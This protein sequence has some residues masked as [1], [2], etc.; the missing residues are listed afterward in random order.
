MKKR[1][2]LFCFLLFSLLAFNILG[3]TAEV[4][5][6]GLGDLEENIE[7]L[8]EK[9]EEIE[10]LPENIETKWDY[11]G[12]E[13]K[14]V[15]LKN[16]LV[17][18]LDSFFTQISVIFEVL[19]GEPYS[20]SLTLFFIVLLWFYLLFKI[21]EILGDFGMFSPAISWAMSFVVVMLI[22]RTDGIKSVVGFFGNLIF[23]QESL[24]LKWII[25]IIIAVIMIFIY[26]FSSLLGESYKATKE[27][28]E[29]EE[30]KRN[31]GILKAYA[32]AIIKSFTK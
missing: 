20:L 2:I 22:S 10:N 18:G 12:N 26:K 9:A 29:K 32:D 7:D 11:L 16:K 24:G 23:S 21:K 30:E 14:N 4:A 25:F 17:S 3:V 13:W 15:L 6:E 28:L 5:V 31:R 8:E 1:N 19:F 27:G